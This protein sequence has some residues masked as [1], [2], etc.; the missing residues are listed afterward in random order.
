M[1]TYGDMVTL[2]LC[3]FVLLYSMSSIS[4][5]NWKALVMSFNPD[6]QVSR[7]ETPGGD[8]PSADADEGGEIVELTQTSI[9]KQIED[10]YQSLVEYV[11]QSGQEST[12]SVTKGDGKV[13]ITF[14]QSVFFDGDSATLRAEAYPIL[15]QVSTSLS[16][17]A[18]AI[19]EVCVMGHTAQASPSKLNNVQVD[20]TL[21]SQRAANVIIYVQQ[22]SIV[23]PARLVSEGIGQWR[24]IASNDTAEGRAQN[25]RVEMVISGRN[26]EEE[27]A[28]GIQSYSTSTE[29]TTIESY[30]TEDEPLEAEG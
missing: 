20:R 17:A 7:T 11:E 24:P 12:I 1:D 26:L 23:D 10:L 16:E 6:A 13:Y 4:E 27:L 18:A 21:S 9:D 2:L 5:D 30:T 15:D 8:G 3:F 28:S 19:D 25:R 14:N 29:I 22:N